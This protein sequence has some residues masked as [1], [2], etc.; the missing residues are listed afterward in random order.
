MCGDRGCVSV[1]I[2]GAGSG[3]KRSTC[4]LG[5]SLVCALRT[6]DA[7]ML[8]CQPEVNWGEGGCAGC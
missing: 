1:S 7:D 2:Q 3:S 8:L 4:L 6:E 5:L